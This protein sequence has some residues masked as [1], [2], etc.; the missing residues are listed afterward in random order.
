M[1]FCY[2][3]SRDFRDGE[4]AYRIGYAH[5]D[6]M[7]RWTRDDHQTGIDPSDDAW[8]SKMIAYPALAVANDRTL[9]FY[10]GN[11]FGVEGFGYATLLES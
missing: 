10:N 6:D 2:L 8:D 5:S 3:G 1:W 11:G 7:K 4:T 9:M